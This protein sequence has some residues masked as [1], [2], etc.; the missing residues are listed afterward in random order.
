MRSEL[1]CALCAALCCTMYTSV[2]IAIMRRSD[3]MR[4][5]AIV[6]PNIE[7]RE[8]KH[9]GTSISEVI[10]PRGGGAAACRR[11]GVGAAA[12]RSHP[13]S[14]ARH[15]RHA[16]QSAARGLADVA[17]HLRWLRLQPAGSDQ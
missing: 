14:H 4:R 12:C 7:Q 6:P 11:L 10:N 13:K 16:A 3:K 15:R 2:W 9:V 8:E 5:S 1:F 17:A